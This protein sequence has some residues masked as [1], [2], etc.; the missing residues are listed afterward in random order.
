MRYIL[1]E[2]YSWFPLLPLSTCSYWDQAE[3]DVKVQYG[4]DLEDISFLFCRGQKISVKILVVR[5][6]HFILF[7]WSR[8]L[9]ISCSDP[10]NNCSSF[11]VCYVSFLFWQDDNSRMM[12]AVLVQKLHAC[13][14][15]QEQVNHSLTY[16]VVVIRLS[17]LR[18]LNFQL[19]ACAHL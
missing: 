9:L 15:Q 5:S 1:L 19:C 14:N 17:Q 18:N 3:I 2:N 7:F 12:F 10:C 4:H 6:V 8:Q 11:F 16:T 13:V